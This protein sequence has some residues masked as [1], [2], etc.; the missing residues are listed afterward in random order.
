MVSLYF[1]SSY[2]PEGCFPIWR[3]DQ[4]VLP[5]ISDVLPVELQQ[6]HDSYRPT[7][8]TNRRI[9]AMPSPALSATAKKNVETIAKVEQQLAGQRT[10][11]DRIGDAIARFFGTLRFIIAHAVFIT[12]WF[13]LTDSCAMSLT[14]SPQWVTRL[15]RRK[16]ES[17]EASVA[18][19]RPPD[20]IPN[21]TLP[22]PYTRGCAFPHV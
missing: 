3:R 1:V 2:C 9:A 6:V 20:G 14:F 15:R 7:D 17:G 13:V 5:N 8:S 21:A 18:S 4:A 19:V 22:C 12:I 11:M 16:I 10:R